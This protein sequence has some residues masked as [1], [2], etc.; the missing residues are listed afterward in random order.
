MSKEKLTP[1]GVKADRGTRTLNVSWADGHTSVLPFD[2]LRAVCPCVV[3][4]GGHA[5][6][7]T[8]PNP[9][10]VRDSP[11]T[12]LQ[13]VN[14]QAMG[15]Y[16]IQLSWSDGHNT[17]IYIWETLRTADPINCGQ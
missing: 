4:K 10:T 9:C 1:T 6:M 8:P 3:C 2:R 17:G 14:I 16:A 11:T 7:G 5:R 13:L 15:T 12:N